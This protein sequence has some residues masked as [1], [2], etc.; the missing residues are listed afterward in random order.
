MVWKHFRL[1]VFVAAFIALA[2]MPLAEW[3]NTAVIFNVPV[4]TGFTITLPLGAGEAN[5]SSASD[6]GPATA[7][8]NFTCVTGTCTRVEPCLTTAFGGSCQAGAAVP[9]FQY[10]NAGNVNLSMTLIFNSSLP[11]GITVGVNSSAS[12]VGNN[13]VTIGPEIPLNNSMEAMIFQELNTT[14]S[15]AC[16]SINVTLYANFTSVSGLVEQRLITH[17]STNAN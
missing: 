13:A 16:C 8:I 12:G 5:A 2:A 9:I 14:A 1:I 6:P 4:D 3:A 7:D 17:N 10:T 11:S 15:P